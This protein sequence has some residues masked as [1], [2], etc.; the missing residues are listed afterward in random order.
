MFLC[1][2]TNAFE[3]EVFFERCEV[4]EFSSSRLPNFVRPIKI[5]IKI[6][7]FADG[8]HFKDFLL[9]VIIF[10]IE[11][12]QIILEEKAQLIFKF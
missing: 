5:L 7:S 9:F 12:T 3:K 1:T 11:Y 2:D 8:K 6:A 4:R 10:V